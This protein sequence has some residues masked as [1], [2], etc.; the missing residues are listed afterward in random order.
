MSKSKKKPPTDDS[1]PNPE[2]SSERT[3]LSYTLENLSA[4]QAVT[5][6]PSSSVDDTRIYILV[7]ATNCNAVSS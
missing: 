5:T 6:H 2:P 7:C 4:H 1:N 3:S